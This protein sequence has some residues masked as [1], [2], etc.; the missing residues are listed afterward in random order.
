MG[1]SAW[2]RDCDALARH[3]T[4]TV[5]PQYTVPGSF[6]KKDPTSASRAES[7]IAVKIP[8]LPL[9]RD[10]HNFSEPI[11]EGGEGNGVM[12]VPFLRISAG[13]RRNVTDLAFSREAGFC[14]G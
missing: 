9:P 13:L 1:W 7:T 3:D 11:F 5:F 8:S 2:T 4:Y 14:G 12:S 10:D 6:H